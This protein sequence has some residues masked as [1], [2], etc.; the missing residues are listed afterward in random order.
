M[1]KITELTEYDA[2]PVA[3][4]MIPM[5]DVS[6]T[7]Q[8]ASGTTKRMPADRVPWT[9]GSSV[10]L[11]GGGTIALGG[12]TL[13]VPKT[14]SAAMVADRV[15]TYHYPMALPWNTANVA[16]AGNNWYPG[17]TGTSLT[18]TL[19]VGSDT[20]FVQII[21]NVDK[22]PTNATVKLRCRMRVT[23]ASTGTIRLAQGTSQIAASEIT[24]TNTTYEWVTSG[25]IKSSLTAGEQTYR[26]YMKN[27][28]G[29]PTAGTVISAALLV[30]E[31]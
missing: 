22:I 19:G 25:D 31:V 28:V 3:T 5:V 6:D 11:T 23:A 20:D 29:T 10:S 17:T 4:D 26:L 16:S 30:V 2:A 14:G 13:T 21:F 1:T 27:S 24:S 15:D 9:D 7:S 12:F 18:P 8:A